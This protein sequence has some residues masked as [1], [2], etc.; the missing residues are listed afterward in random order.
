MLSHTCASTKQSPPVKGTSTCPDWRCWV[1]WNDLV[2]SCTIKWDCVSPGGALWGPRA[3]QEIQL[4]ALALCTCEHLTGGKRLYSW[5]NLRWSKHKFLSSGCSGHAQHITAFWLKRFPLSTDA[6]SHCSPPIVSVPCC[7]EPWD[8]QLLTLAVRG[9]DHLLL[10]FAFPPY[11]NVTSTIPNLVLQ[12]VCSF[13][14]IAFCSW[15]FS[16]TFWSFKQITLSSFTLAAL[17]VGVLQ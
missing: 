14:L 1:E 3:Q 15:S 5:R 11:I 17:F 6:A 13:S 9:A 16:K 2:L 7:S 10:V 12:S 4:I 8:T